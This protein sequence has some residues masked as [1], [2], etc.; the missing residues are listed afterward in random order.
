LITLKN[1]TY[2]YPKKNGFALADIDFDIRPGEIFTLLGPN[3]SGKT[4]LISVGGRCPHLP[5]YNNPIK[6]DASNI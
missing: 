1:I 3:G 6:K 2:K 4:T 5:L